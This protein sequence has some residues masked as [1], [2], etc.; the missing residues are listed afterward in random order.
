[1]IQLRQDLITALEQIKL[2]EVAGVV[3]SDAR[4]ARPPVLLVAA[5][6]DGRL[7]LPWEEDPNAER[8]RRAVLEPEFAR[9]I[10]HGESE[11]LV[12]GDYRQAAEHYQTAIAAT[13]EPSAKTYA[14]LLM[15]RS[16]QKAHRLAESRAEYE[17]VMTAPAEAVDEHGVPLALYAVPP[18][19]KQAFRRGPF[20]NG[21][22]K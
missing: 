5:L 6:I 16:L 13:T 1:L 12:S 11:E 8:F 14:R 2:Q 3:S 4:V 22:L 21:L 20:W 15:A 7:R 10:R 18:L 9:L 17:R 19:T